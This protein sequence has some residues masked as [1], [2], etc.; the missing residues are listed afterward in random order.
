M[1][2]DWTVNDTISVSLGLRLKPDKST[3]LESSVRLFLSHCTM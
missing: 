2:T 3:E 1:T